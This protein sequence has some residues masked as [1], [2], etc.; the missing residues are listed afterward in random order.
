MF[1]NRLLLCN[2]TSVSQRTHI[3][4][5]KIPCIRNGITGI[6]EWYKTSYF[7]TIKVP[8]LLRIL[9]LY[10]TLDTFRWSRLRNLCQ[11]LPT[12]GRLDFTGPVMTMGTD[13]LSVTMASWLGL[14]HWCHGTHVL[15]CSLL[16]IPNPLQTKLSPA[17]S[18]LLNEAERVSRYG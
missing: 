4:K 12:L 18:W 15:S 9:N 5:N 10:L 1:Y 14:Q 13:C 7:N 2:F 16:P 17:S 8:K 3:C 6:S 11:R